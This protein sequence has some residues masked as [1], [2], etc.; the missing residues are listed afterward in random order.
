MPWKPVNP[1]RKPNQRE[2]SSQRGYGGKWRSVRKRYLYDNPFCVGCG[3]VAEVVDHIIPHRGD[4]GLLYDESN[5][6]PLCKRCHD[7]KTGTYD[8]RPTYGYK[9]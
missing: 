4:E 2:N 3:R 5:F 1:D 8:S 6:Q 7:R 9:I